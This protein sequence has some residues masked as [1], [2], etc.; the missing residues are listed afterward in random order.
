MQ[1]GASTTGN[2][3]C[4]TAVRPEYECP[5]K[6]DQAVLWSNIVACHLQLA[7]ESSGDGSC[8]SCCGRC[9][10]LAKGYFRFASVY[11]ALGPILNRGRH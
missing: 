5:T 2:K 7:S 3:A 4:R 1:C 9:E 11:V 8:P 6:A 10:T